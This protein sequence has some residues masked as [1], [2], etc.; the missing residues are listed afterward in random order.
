MPGRQFPKSQEACTQHAHKFSAGSTFCRHSETSTPREYWKNGRVG[1]PLEE[2]TQR[3]LFSDFFDIIKNLDAVPSLKQSK[4]CTP[5]NNTAKPPMPNK[6]KAMRESFD[7]LKA[8]VNNLMSRSSESFQSESNTATLW[9][10]E[11]T[12]LASL[13]VGNASVPDFIRKFDKQ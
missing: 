1:R 9:S 6:L 7:K 3:M 11:N 10:F 5:E 12:M 8:M 2:K 4:A 13:P